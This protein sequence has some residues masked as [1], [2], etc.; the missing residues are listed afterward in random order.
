MHV[1][2]GRNLCKALP[3]YHAL[4]G[5]DFTASFSGKGKVNPLKKLKKNKTALKALGGLGC[6]GEICEEQLK[7]VEQFVCDMYGN[8][9]SNSVNEA[10]LEKFLEKYRPKKEVLSFHVLEEWMRAHCRHVHEFWP[11]K[12]SV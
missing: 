5:S 3:G 1:N 6:S 8:G 12:S 4:T 2:L 7:D 10:R 9:Q 11:K